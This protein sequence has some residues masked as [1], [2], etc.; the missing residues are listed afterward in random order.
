VSLIATIEKR[1]SKAGAT[2]YRVRVRLSGEKASSRTFKRLTDS[3]AWAAYAE[4]D[5]GRG[6]SVPDAKERR[7][8]LSDL[9]DRYLVEHLPLKT[10]NRDA[11]KQRK[12]LE[13]WKVR[14]GHVSLPRLTPQAVGDFRHQIA[15]RV[16][17]DGSRIRD[18]NGNVL[19][20]EDSQGA[21]LKVEYLDGGPWLEA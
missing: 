10:R 11:D 1:V 13:R 6:V 16:K 12:I 19:S 7:R 3:K 14:A 9:I 20:V 21:V 4:A 18:Q 2:A 17:R 8:T 5:T 15:G